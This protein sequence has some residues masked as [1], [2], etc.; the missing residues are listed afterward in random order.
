MSLQFKKLLNA[1]KEEIEAL[2]NRI[3]ERDKLIKKGSNHK[4]YTAI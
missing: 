3:K 2:N 1:Y 4:W